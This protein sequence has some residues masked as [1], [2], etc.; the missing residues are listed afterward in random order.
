[1]DVCSSIKSFVIE[2]QLEVQVLGNTSLFNYSASE[3]SHY[4]INPDDWH[5][6]TESISLVHESWLY[7][8]L[9]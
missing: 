1:M 7:I 5:S 2:K 3:E 9:A 6:H 8:Y 4:A